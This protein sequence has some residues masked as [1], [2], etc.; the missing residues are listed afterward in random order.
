MAEQHVL[1]KIIEHIDNTLSDI[2]YSSA[3]LPLI[4][5]NTIGNIKS[6]CIGAREMSRRK[7]S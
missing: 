7:K 6:M 3:A 5:Q 4:L 2:D 1:D